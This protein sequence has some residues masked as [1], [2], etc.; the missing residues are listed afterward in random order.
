VRTDLTI[1]EAEPR[2]SGTLKEI[3]DLSFSRFF[4]FFAAQSVNS[5]EGKVLVA[6]EYRGVVG[7]AKLI[8]F[9]FIDQKHGCILW[10]AVHQNRRREGVASALV[11]A[12]GEDLK[13]GGAEAV[14]ASVHRRNRASLATFAK[15]EFSRVGFVDLWRLFSWRIFQF[16]IDIWLAPGEVVLMHS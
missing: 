10:L 13:H 14:F 8:D 6:E 11:E 16:Y 12:G 15:K 7:F 4:R 3:T 5:E 9:Y 2:N 1:R